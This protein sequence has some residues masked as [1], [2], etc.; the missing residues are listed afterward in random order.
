MSVK[1]Q[2]FNVGHSVIARAKSEDIV[3]YECGKRRKPSGAA[4]SDNEPIAIDVS[5]LCQIAC[6]VDAVLHIRNSPLAVQHLAIGS[7]IACAASV[8]HI[9]DCEPAGGHILACERKF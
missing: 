9:H 1:R 8:V 5:P 4:A 3:E 6:C 2:G 7:S